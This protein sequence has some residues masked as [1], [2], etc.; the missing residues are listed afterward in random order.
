MILIILLAG[1]ETTVLTLTY[2]S[3]HLAIEP[4]CQQKLYEELIEAF[5]ADGQIGYEELNRLPYLDACISETLRLYP[6]IPRLEREAGCDFELGDTGLKL[7][8]GMLVEIP[9]YA[10]QHSDLYYDNPDQFNPNR[11]MP[12]NKHKLEPYAYLPFGTG[13]R[14]CIGMMFGLMELKL[15]LAHLVPK[16]VFKVTDKTEKQLKFRALSMNMNAYSVT[17]GVGKR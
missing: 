6:P 7:T 11:F 9:I 4:D 14:N 13:P 10:I 15:A 5:G 17:V 12:E 1:F 2:L 3:Y 8:K 16:Y